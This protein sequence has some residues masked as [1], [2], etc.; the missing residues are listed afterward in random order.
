VE[1]S[2]PTPDTIIVTF[3]WKNWI[4]L[5]E[6]VSNYGFFRIVY[7]KCRLSIGGVLIFCNNISFYVRK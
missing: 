4:D 1:G 6:E 5:D 2:S 3:Y 7:Q